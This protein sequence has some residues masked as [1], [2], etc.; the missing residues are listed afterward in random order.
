VWGTWLQAACELDTNKNPSWGRGVSTGVR[1]LA[2]Q[3]GGHTSW[4]YKFSHVHD[5]H[6]TVGLG[7][8]NEFL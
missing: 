6:D 3:W 5:L 4:G 7:N 2:R 1:S 8:R